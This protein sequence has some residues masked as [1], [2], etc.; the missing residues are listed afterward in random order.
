M[1][2]AQGRE[3]VLD[4]RK[5][6]YIGTQ[7]KVKLA[8]LPDGKYVGDRKREKSKITQKFY[9]HFR[10]WVVISAIY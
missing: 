6:G 2:V 7:L 10:D 4:I 5:I 1:T 9:I 3:T 8:G